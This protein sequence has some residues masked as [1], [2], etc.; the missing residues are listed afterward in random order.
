VLAVLEWNEEVSS[1]S[2][3]VYCGSYKN[4]WLPPSEYFLEVI[5]IHCKDFGVTALKSESNMD[6]VLK[7][8][9]A[10]ECLE[11]PRIDQI[12][13]LSATI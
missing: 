12:T 11:D 6:E 5:V 3:I 13:D 9:F 10:H 8:D 2:T 7:F 1:R 4:S